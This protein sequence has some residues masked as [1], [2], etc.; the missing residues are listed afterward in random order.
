MIRLLRLCLPL[1]LALALNTGCSLVYSRAP[2]TAQWKAV[3]S[4]TWNPS[5][6]CQPAGSLALLDAIGAV[7]YGVIGFLMLDESD[8]AFERKMS[9]VTLLSAGALATS[10]YVGFQTNDEC[11]RFDAA[12][13]ERFGGRWHTP[14]PT[15]PGPWAPGVK[16]A[17]VAPPS[18]PGSTP[19]P[20]R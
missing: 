1:A 9:I 6:R 14:A 17:P 15:Q 11:D 7:L 19:A 8:D 18:Q 5:M 16:P 20:Q 12:V 13:A 10:S 2:T 4:G 3:E